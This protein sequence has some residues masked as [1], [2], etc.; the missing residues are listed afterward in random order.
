MRD[1]FQR[2]GSML[3]LI[4]GGY[5]TTRTRHKKS[6]KSL[7]LL[8]FQIPLVISLQ[9]FLRSHGKI[10]DPRILTLIVENYNNIPPFIRHLQEGPGARVLTFFYSELAG[11]FYTASTTEEKQKKLKNSGLIEIDLSSSAA[12]FGPTL[13]DKARKNIKR[14]L[15]LSP[16]EGEQCM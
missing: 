8:S 11:N 16:S 9:R 1:T 13:L 15:K 6:S 2:I 4:N 7:I 10:Y 3:G 14:N 12:I 5:S